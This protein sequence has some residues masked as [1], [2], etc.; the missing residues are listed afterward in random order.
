MVTT[1]IGKNYN[2]VYKEI[3]K[4]KD[5][6]NLFSRFEEYDPIKLD[7]HQ[8]FTFAFSRN[9]DILRPSVSEYLLSQ[10]FHFNYPDEKSWALL[11]THDIDDIYVR[12]RHLFLSLLYFP[13][14]GDL[15]GMYNLIK[16]RLNKRYSPYN[17]FKK[18]ISVEQQYNATSTFYFLSSPDDIF[19][20]KYSLEEIQDTLGFIIDQNCEIGFH[21]GYYHYDDVEK[22]KKE[23]AHMEKL[24]GGPLIGVRN[25]VL[26]FQTPQSWEILANAGFRYDSTYGYIDMIGFRNGMC[27][28][29]IPYNLNTKQPIDI[30]EMPLNI[31]DWTISYIMKNNPQQAWTLIKQLLDTVKKNQGVLNILWHNWTFSFP[32]SVGNIFEKEWTKLYQK[33]LAYAHENNAWITNCKDFYNYYQKHDFVTH[34]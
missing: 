15:K 32:T 28:P 30:L 5:I 13:K 27:H 24:I 4:N 23:K 31:Q 9:V 14:N 19:G 6:W 25:H 18:I 2:Q 12:N 7:E 1:I 29:F 11:L 26:R 17:N 34:S 8:R 21:T 16:G 22:I 20:Y 3:K 33:I 10:G